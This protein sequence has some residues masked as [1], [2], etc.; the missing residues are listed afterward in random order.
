M[1]DMI[2]CPKCATHHYR[3]DP[4]P[5]E[6]EPRK[7]INRF[8]DYRRGVETGVMKSATPNV[9]RDLLDE[10]DRLQAEVKRLKSWANYD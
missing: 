7:P 9:V 8:D 2:R 5:D 3:N 6:P 4:C 10:I 1:G